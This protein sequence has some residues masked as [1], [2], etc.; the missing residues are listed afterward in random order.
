MDSINS[1]CEAVKQEETKLEQIPLRTFCFPVDIS[2]VEARLPAART[3]RRHLGGSAASNCKTLLSR[4]CCR[5]AQG[6]G[7]RVGFA[8][9][10]SVEATAPNGRVHLPPWRQWGGA[11]ND[12]WS[13]RNRDGLARWRCTGGQGATPAQSVFIRASSRGSATSTR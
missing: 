7:A 13:P 2:S 6:T 10:P 12:R 11:A 4:L 9:A 1:R 8:I 3:Q 5:S